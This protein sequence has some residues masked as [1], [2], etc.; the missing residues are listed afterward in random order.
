MSKPGVL[1]VNLGSPDS[2]AVGDV[3]KY[4]RQFLMDGRVIDM[5]YPGRFLLV[6]AAI[7]PFI[8][9]SGGRRARPW[10]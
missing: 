4:L 9:R 6:N 2:P 3:R 5:A 8:R 1:L 10:S 7:L